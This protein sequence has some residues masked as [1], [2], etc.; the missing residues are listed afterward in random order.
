MKGFEADWRLPQNLY[1]FAIATKD[2]KAYIAGGKT[3][4]YM[5][6]L[7]VTEASVYEISV[8]RNDDN[9]FIELGKQAG[10]EKSYL[11]KEMAPMVEPR[12]DFALVFSQTSI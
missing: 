3:R 7:N 12:E 8:G 11:M 2:N 10:T 5:S 6:G 9:D 4:K 1:K